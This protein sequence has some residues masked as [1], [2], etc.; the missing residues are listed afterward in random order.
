MGFSMSRSIDHSNNKAV[1]VYLNITN[2]TYIPVHICAPMIWNESDAGVLF[3]WNVSASMFKGMNHRKDGT[4]TIRKRL[5]EF[6]IDTSTAGVV[7]IFGIFGEC[8]AVMLL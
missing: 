1:T 6:I 8:C 4:Q 2:N 3:C 7:L 5:K